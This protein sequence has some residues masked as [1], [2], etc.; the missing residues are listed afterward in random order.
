MVPSRLQ[1]RYL[2]FLSITLTIAVPPP[3]VS[4]CL[5]TKTGAGSDFGAFPNCSGEDIMMPTGVLHVLVSGVI[6]VMTTTFVQRAWAYSSELTPAPVTGYTTDG[7]GTTAAPFFTDATGP[8]EPPVTS[9]D[10][11]ICPDEF[12][13]CLADSTCSSCLLERSTTSS[14]KECLTYYTDTTTSEGCQFRLDEM[15]SLIHI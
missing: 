13:A 1:S 6:A 11:F 10:E 15:L 14:T 7:T 4:R 5:P 3:R 12:S 2:I 8:T 9:E